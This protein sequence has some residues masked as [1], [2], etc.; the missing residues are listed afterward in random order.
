M[1]YEPDIFQILFEHPY[2]EF[3]VPIEATALLTELL[4]TLKTTR[5]FEGTSYSNDIFELALC[6]TC[7]CGYEEER[8]AWDR[9]HRHAPDCYSNKL[10]KFE[11]E[12]AT[13][14]GILPYSKEWD[15]TV[16]AFARENGFE[17]TDFH[18]TCSYYKDED[19]WKH[20][21]AHHEDCS[22]VKPN[23]LYKPTNL[24]ISWY[25]EVGRGMSANQEISTTEL[26]DIIT[27][28]LA[29]IIKPS[30]R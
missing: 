17:D 5:S 9:E 10:R 19:D 2:Y 12:L 18:C 24:K 21:H 13:R 3:Q 25:L 1:K 15:K 22:A 8:V 16:E 4:N 20:T 7:N 14:R 27:R 11:E 29:S 6:G 30:P 28:C 23:F 26:R